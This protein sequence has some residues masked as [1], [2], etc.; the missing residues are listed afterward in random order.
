MNR[1]PV[2]EDK[3]TY[4][5]EF[6]KENRDNAYT[7]RKLAQ[8]LWD[9]YS[10]C[11]FKTFDEIL[12]EVSDIITKHVNKSGRYKQ[13][14]P[15]QIIEHQ[16]HPLTYQYM[17]VTENTVLREF[18][19]QPDNFVEISTN[20]NAQLSLEELMD[21]VGNI[22]SPEK[23]IETF[24]DKQTEEIVEPPMQE[25][26]DES[27]LLEDLKACEKVFGKQNFKSSLIYWIITSEN[28]QQTLAEI[29]EIVAKY[30]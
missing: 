16:T 21:K 13:I 15:L 28:K 17:D 23:S 8:Y 4:V 1:L 24:I 14:V 26:I 11:E 18:N 9:N 10:Y 25:S 7:R 19:S 2:T 20:K 6:L 22:M 30:A 3:F 29:Q 5:I 12:G 27:V